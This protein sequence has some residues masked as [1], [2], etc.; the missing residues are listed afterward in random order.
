LLGFSDNCWKILSV[1]NIYSINMNIPISNF[2]IFTKI[3]SVNL[4]VAPTT[5]C[6]YSRNFSKNYFVIKF[7]IFK[8]I[9][10][11]IVILNL[12]IVKTLV[13]Y[14]FLVKYLIRC[15]L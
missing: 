13:F 2:I 10:C 14:Y 8:L 3:R 15:A 11:I 9:E 4:P 6:V 12:E 5:S 1:V 7:G